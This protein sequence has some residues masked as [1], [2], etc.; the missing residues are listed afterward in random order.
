MAARVSIV[1]AGAVRR[2]GLKTAVMRTTTRPTVSAISG[3]MPA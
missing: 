1:S 2:S 3:E